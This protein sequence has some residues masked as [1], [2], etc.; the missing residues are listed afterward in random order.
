[1]NGTPVIE[2]IQLTRYRFPFHNVGYDLSFAMGA[3]YEPGQKGAR[4]AL[5]N[6]L[7]IRTRA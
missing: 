6:S 7:S 5:G 3:F 4:T 1:M 2:R